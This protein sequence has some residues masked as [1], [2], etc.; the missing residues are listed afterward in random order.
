MFRRLFIVF[1]LVLFLAVGFS[2]RAYVSPGKPTGFVNDYANILPAAEQQALE[3]KLVAFSRESGNEISLV[4]VSDLGGETIENFAV[5]LFEEWG[6]G[7]EKQDNGVLLVVA[8]AE[9]QMRLEVGYGLEGAL[10]DL[11]S[12]Q[13]ITATLR[14]AFQS[15]DY[16]GGLDRAIEQIMTATRGEY[17]TGLDN[18]RQAGN[19]G[20]ENWFW[21]LFFVFY[22]LS[23]L[24]RHLAKS[25]SWWQGGAFGA[26]IGLLIALIFLRT[27]LFLL[28]LPAVF[29]VL[30]LIFDF[31]VSR[32]LPQPK[33]GS[34]RNNLWWFL[35][36]GSGGFGGSG[37]GF[38]G[39][40]GGRSGGG[41]SS[42]G[43]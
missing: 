43:W 39:F 28:I 18:D 24:R 20:F 21:L 16:Y 10:P 27:L 12:Y 35:G 40:G 36:G 29:I 14:P 2:A 19:L 34:G 11:L 17:P 41:G 32:V 5:R 31:L 33:P 38:G 30:G 3:D 42:G 1:S 26:V 23:A 13:I 22:L 8:L 9:R 15:E 4:I 6:I 7:R 25:R 37:G